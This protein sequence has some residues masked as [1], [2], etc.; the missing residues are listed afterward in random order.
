[1]P[2]LLNVDEYHRVVTYKTQLHM[3]N[4][5]IAE[6]LGIRRQTVAAILKRAEDT[7]SPEAK[8]KGRKRKTKTAPSLR[9]AA[10][11]NRLREVSLA[12]PFKTPRVLK[13]ELRLRCSLATIKRRLRGFHLRGRRPATAIFLTDTAK[14]NRLAWCRAHKNR[15]WTKVMFTDEVKIETSAHGMNWVRRPANCRYDD[16]YIRE[17]NRQGRCRVMVW[18]A[19]THDQMLDLVVIDGRMNKERYI[20]DV[21]NPVVR[22]YHDLNPNMIF[23]QD[24]APSHTANVV[25]SWFTRNNIEL[26]D[27]PAQSPDLSPIENLWNILK[28]EVGPLNH[29]GP[30]QTDELVVIVRAA[31]ERIKVEKPRL[32]RTLYAQMKRRIAQCIKK[33]GGHIGHGFNRR[34]N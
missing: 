1:M 33:K 11:N 25:K 18:G 24:N 9:T 13:N 34:R 22:P 4:V 31:W 17:I 26:L 32:L 19:M 16:K 7:G 5:A 27:W 10:D 6:E 29:I 8:I 14:Q 15:D 30:N 3:T 28:D 21:L 23:Q 20:E 2:K 12:N